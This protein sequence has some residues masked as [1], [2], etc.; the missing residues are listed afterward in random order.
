MKTIL[1]ICLSAALSLTP[2]WSGRALAAFDLRPLPPDERGAATALAAGLGEDEEG[3][4]G[5]GGTSGFRL[6]AVRVYGFR[7]FGVEGIDFGAASIEVGLPGQTSVRLGC[8]VLRTLSYDERVY[9]VAWAWMPGR[10]RLEPAL[11]LGTV[12]LD[13]LPIDRALLADFTF[14]ASPAR[15]LVIVCRA[16]NP[17]ALRLLRSKGRCPTEITAG[18]G[19][20]LRSGLAFG[21]EIAKQ[22]GFPTSVATGAEVSLVGG[23]LLRAGVNTEPEEFSMG[24]GFRVSRIAL[25]VSATYHLDLGVTHE[26]GITYRP[27]SG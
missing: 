12:A 18:A 24:I 1:G 23:V 8:Q 7:P 16:H 9:E 2:A 4:A 19:Y 15:D 27:G 6:E 5:P 10:L 17:F 22:A 20:R 11:R 3:S 14:K 21:V 25:D 13:G 26:A